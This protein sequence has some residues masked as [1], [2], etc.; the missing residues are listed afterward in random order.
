L[1]YNSTMAGK[2]AFLDSDRANELSRLLTSERLKKTGLASRSKSASRD[3][4]VEALR[5]VVRSSK[6][7]TTG[8]PLGV[9]RQV[10]KKLG[11]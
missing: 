10:L 6:G 1:D 4:D 8:N 2:M 11:A 3:P 7:R 5:R 9:S